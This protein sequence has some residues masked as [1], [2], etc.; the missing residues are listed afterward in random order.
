[1]FPE[2]ATYTQRTFLE[3]AEE[4]L[5]EVLS[6]ARWLAPSADEAARLAEEALRRGYR[7]AREASPPDDFRTWIVGLVAAE[8]A[9]NGNGSSPPPDGVDAEL[10]V[11]MWTLP[12][13]QR[14]PIVLSDVAGFSYEQIAR[15]VGIPIGAVRARI[16]GARVRLLEALGMGA[17]GPI[18]GSALAS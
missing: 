16:H 1:M 4:H 15:V 9:G 6:V 3:L 12:S 5:E 13:W 2:A 10:P 7:E 18:E 14:V 8:Y 11:A 17:M